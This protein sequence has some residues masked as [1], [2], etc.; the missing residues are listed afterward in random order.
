MTL[1][2]HRKKTV[3]QEAIVP[4][5][6][7]VGS[8]AGNLATVVENDWLVILANYGTNTANGLTI[9]GV[10]LTPASSSV[11]IHGYHRR[12]YLHKVTAGGTNVQFDPVGYGHIQMYRVRGAN[13]LAISDPLTD[14]GTASPLQITV[15]EGQAAYIL[16]DDRSGAVPECTLQKSIFIATYFSVMFAYKPAA[17][18]GSQVSV[19]RPGSPA[20]SASSCVIQ[21]N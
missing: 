2:Y 17:F 5:W 11:D 6:A 14:R 7:R 3:V 15:P 8:A 19:T 10:A 21:A 16:T 13:T 12:V 20:T 4:T 1:I 18:V 9:N